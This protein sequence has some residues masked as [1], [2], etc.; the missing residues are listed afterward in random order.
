MP[1]P[2]PL[3]GALA[4]H[5][6]LADLTARLARSRACFDA[7]RGEL[8]EALR[9][10]VQPGPIDDAGWTLLA[11]NAAVASKLRHLLP[12]LEAVLRSQGAAAPPIRI[13]I[14]RLP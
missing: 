7:L 4:R 13:R 11:A 10:A 5:G 6:G 12:R 9:D 1:L 14:R 2:E 8:P 3:A